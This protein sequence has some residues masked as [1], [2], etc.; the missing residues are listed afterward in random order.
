MDNTENT[1]SKIDDWFAKAVPEPTSK[2]LS[3]Q[4]GVHVEETAELLQELKGKKGFEIVDQA[5]AAVVMSLRNFSTALKESDCVEIPA[6]KRELVLDAL[7][8][9]IVTAVGVANFAGMDINNGLAEVNRSNWSKFDD[10]GE[11]IFDVNRKIMK[12]PN[13]SKPVLT[14]FV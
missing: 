4:I 2:N 7:A 11:P 8:D 9:S 14:L 3:T 10:E 6:E 5:I 13:Y 12:G 1:V